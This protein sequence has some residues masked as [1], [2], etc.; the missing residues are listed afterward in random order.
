MMKLFAFRLDGYAQ[1]NDSIIKDQDGSR[2]EN[3]N[4]SGVLQLS[5]YIR[6]S[7]PVTG[8]RL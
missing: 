8:Q 2:F 4:H 1:Q 6:Y 5:K 3:A 7:N